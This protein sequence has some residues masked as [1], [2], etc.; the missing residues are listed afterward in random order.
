MGSD[1][2]CKQCPGK[3]HWLKHC[4]MKYR[5]EYKEVK[6]KQTVKELKEKYLKASKAKGTVQEVIARMKAE[7]KRLQNGVMDMMKWAAECLNRLGE[8]ALKPDPLST[9]EYIDLLI[10]GEKAEGNLVWNQGVQ[11]L[12]EVREQEEL[13]GKARRGEPVLK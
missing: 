2:N 3:C 10:E 9:P 4:N 11:Y 7:Y 8:I 1:G 5:W 13:M 6:E 12:M